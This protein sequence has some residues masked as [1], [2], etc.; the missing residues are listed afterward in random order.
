MRIWFRSTPVYSARAE[1]LQLVV[2]GLGAFALATAITLAEPVPLLDRAITAFAGYVIWSCTLGTV[3]RLFAWFRGVPFVTYA[4]ARRLRKGQGRQWR[5]QIG[6]MSI[7][8][9]FA[10]FEVVSGVPMWHLSAFRLLG[11]LGAAVVGAILAS[12]ATRSLT[13][14]SPRHLPPRA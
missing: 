12:L 5:V 9:A 7:L 1:G 4:K 14:G 6:A 11:M 2:F 10:M 3:L 8:L 13:L